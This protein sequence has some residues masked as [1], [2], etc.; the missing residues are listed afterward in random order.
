GLFIT[1]DGDNDGEGTNFKFLQ[2][3]AIAAA[4]GLTVDTASYDPRNP[5]PVP[6]P[7]TWATMAGGLAALAAWSRRRRTTRSVGDR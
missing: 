5:V 1:Q 4:N 7:G 2:W 6:E 3:S